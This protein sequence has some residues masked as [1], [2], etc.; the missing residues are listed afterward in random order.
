MK[1]N[2]RQVKLDIIDDTVEN[3]VEIL[4]GDNENQNS[5]EIDSESNEITADSNEW[6]TMPKKV[7][8]S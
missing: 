2:D 8:L 1:N 4:V 7:R 3:N 6:I 5:V